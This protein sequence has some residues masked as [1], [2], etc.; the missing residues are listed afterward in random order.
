MEAHGLTRYAGGVAS[1][2]EDLIEDLLLAAEDAAGITPDI[3]IDQLTESEAAECI[4]QL[5]DA[6]DAI[7]S[8]T[9]ADPQSYA[10]KLMTRLRRGQSVMPGSWM[11]SR[12]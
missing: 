3:P 7:A 10:L 4:R 12:R 11:M 9:V 8:G 6:L 1:T 5:R 2:P